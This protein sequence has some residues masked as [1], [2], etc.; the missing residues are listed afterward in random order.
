MTMQRAIYGNWQ[1]K[2]GQV[3]ANKVKFTI[4]RD[5]TISDI[6]IEETAGPFLDLASR[7]AIEQTSRLPPLPAAFNQPRLIVHLFFEYKR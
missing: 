7:R 5:G 2:Q 6:V 1:Q 4:Q 3:A